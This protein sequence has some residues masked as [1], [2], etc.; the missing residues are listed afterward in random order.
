MHCSGN[1]PLPLSRGEP[2]HCPGLSRPVTGGLFP[3]TG[4]AVTVPY[5]YINMVRV[6][7]KIV[8]I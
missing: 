1:T 2:L 6:D 8:I 5:S 7:I 4:T 3:K